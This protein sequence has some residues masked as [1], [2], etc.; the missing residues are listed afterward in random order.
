[1]YASMLSDFSWK[2]MN[3]TLQIYRHEVISNTLF[4]DGIHHNFGK[5]KLAEQS[6][7]SEGI[8]YN[9]T[10]GD[11]EG[12]IE[13]LRQLT[14]TTRLLKDLPACN[15][16]PFKLTYVFL[17]KWCHILQRRNTKKALDCEVV[18]KG[19]A[20]VRSDKKYLDQIMYNLLTNAFKYAHFGTRIEIGCRQEQSFSPVQFSVSDFGIGITDNQE[21]P[22]KLFYR[23]G[24]N[25][26][27]TTAR[28]EDSTGIGLYLAQQI[29]TKRL[30]TR[31]KHECTLISDFCVP[32]LQPYLEIPLSLRDPEVTKQVEA[33]LQRL[34]DEGVYDRIISK[35]F[36]SGKRYPA[37]TKVIEAIVSNHD[38]C[39]SKKEKYKT[40]EV[41][42]SFEI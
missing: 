14:E 15:L 4:L 17:M 8:A 21:D 39:T 35:S 2:Q 28:D 16:E 36:M 33:E 22:Y 3:Q 20:Y 6:N 30:G 29:A 12:V 27:E 42:F 1:L 10:R 40:Y 38:V 32:L 34:R 13:I 9:K 25:A 18:L 37:Q 41:V 23:E 5:Y 19:D 24:L 11:M 7:T 31:I 26:G